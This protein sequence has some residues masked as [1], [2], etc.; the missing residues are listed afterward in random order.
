MWP[1]FLSI[2]CHASNTSCDVRGVTSAV[3]FLFVTACFPLVLFGDWLAR[4]RGQRRRRYVPAVVGGTA[5]IAA[6]AAC[7]RPNPGPGELRA[8]ASQC[9]HTRLTR[10]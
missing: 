5:A 7:G 1:E 3:R 6:A 10:A 4:P 2:S 8:A 9:G